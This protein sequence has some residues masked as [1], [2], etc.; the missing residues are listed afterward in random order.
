MCGRYLTPNQAAIERRY[1]LGRDG[2][3]PFPA[4]YNVT[5]VFHLGFYDRI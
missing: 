3:N 2:N 5:R 1:H 4:R